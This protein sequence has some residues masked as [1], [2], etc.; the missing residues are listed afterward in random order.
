MGQDTSGRVN[1]KMAVNKFEYRCTKCDASLLLGVY[2]LEGN[3]HKDIDEQDCD[4]IIKRIYSF[5]GAVLKGS[6]WYSVDKRR[7]DGGTIGI[8]P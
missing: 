1:R 6:G 8:D 5:G 3:H 4:G 7:T 2:G